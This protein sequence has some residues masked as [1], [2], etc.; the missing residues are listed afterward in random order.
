MGAI[1][2]LVVVFS[3]IIRFYNLGFESLWMDEFIQTYT[4]SASSIR[5]IITKAASQQQP[6][7]DYLIGLALDRLGLAQSDWWVRFPSALFGV[8]A[9]VMLIWWSIRTLGNYTALAAGMILA[10]SPLHLAMSQEARPYA[11]FVFFTLLCLLFFANAYA[12]PSIKNLA[13]FSFALFL[14]LLTRWVGPIVVTINFFIFVVAHNLYVRV[15]KRR[16]PD[17]REIPL[18]RIL[19]SLF[20]PTALYL[21]FFFNIHKYS[22]AYIAEGGGKSISG[23]VIQYTEMLKSTLIECFGSF[24][25]APLI[26]A[27]LVVILSYP[28][29]ERKRLGRT[30]DQQKIDNLYLLIFLSVLTGFIVIYPLLYVLKSNVPSKPQYLLLMAPW[31]AFC[32]GALIDRI[33]KFLT[34]HSRAAGLIVFVVLL[35]AFTL[36]MYTKTAYLLGTKHKT[37][38]R[39][40]GEIVNQY[41]ESQPTLFISITNA[42]TSWSPPIYSIPR[43]IKNVENHLTIRTMA[44]GNYNKDYKFGTIYAVVYKDFHG[45]F[46]NPKAKPLKNLQIHDLNELTLYR[47]PGSPENSTQRLIQLL[48]YLAS[49]A[50]KGSGL[51][52]VYLAKSQA[53]L[54]SGNVQAAKSAFNEAF[55]QCRNQN[56]RNIFL[57]R[58]ETGQISLQ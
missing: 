13:L 57:Q 17:P 55:S 46:P 42:F 37:D 34:R 24:W 16:D 14:L 30:D 1:L 19:T 48:N 8:G 31:G 27:G 50:D 45:I 36:P 15:A 53:L 25:L 41:V 29:C 23:L 10:V 4:Y 47:Y 51:V 32:L 12:K 58:M 33:R 52:E 2:F 38:W 3:G 56:E 43:Y 44:S 18:K 54:G 35:L 21:P 28:Y 49:G 5:E 6:P 9:V 20:L 26:L 22:Q 40:L 11:I 7:L 39:G